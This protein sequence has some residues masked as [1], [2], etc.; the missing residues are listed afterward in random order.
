[1]EARKTLDFMISYFKANLQSAMEYRANFLMQ[2]F[3]MLINDAI[4]LVFWYIIFNQFNTINGWSFDDLLLLYGLT[5][6]VIGLERFFMGNAERI[7]EIIAKGGLDF[8]LTLPKSVLLHI[9]VS[10]SDYSGF[11]DVMFGLGV[12]ILVL[13]ANPASVALFLLLT[14]V[15]FALIV[16]LAIVSGSFAFFINGTGDLQ[17]TII[18][19]IIMFS[20]Y[21]FSVFSGWTRLLLLTIFPIGFIAGIPVE[22]LHT[23]S[24]L[25]IA[26]LF[27]AS[28]AF[29]LIGIKLFY[30]GLKRYES[31]NLIVARI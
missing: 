15:S 3:G 16:G 27:I 17:D 2:S 13:H 8:Y 11:G 31:G 30:V 23:H 19:I 6:L 10:R 14:A 21:P 4:I 25:L 7:A 18:N 9:L 20:T 1:M 29:L 22:I 28:S 24:P 12:G 5:A 26:E